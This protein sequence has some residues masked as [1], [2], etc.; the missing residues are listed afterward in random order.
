MDNEFT[1]VSEGKIKESIKEQLSQMPIAYQLAI[2]YF[3]WLKKCQEIGEKFNLLE[4]EIHDLKTKVALVLLGLSNMDALHEFLDNEIGGTGWEIIEDSIIENILD[5]MSELI[6]MIEKYDI[7]SPTLFYFEDIYTLDLPALLKNSIL[8]GTRDIPNNN[9]TMKYYDCKLDTTFLNAL[10]TLRIGFAWEEKEMKICPQ[11]FD[12]TLLP[13]NKK[14]NDNQIAFMVDSI[15]KSCEG[16]PDQ[17]YGL[18]DLMRFKGGTCSFMLF[19]HPNGHDIGISQNDSV[20]VSVNINI[21]YEDF[22]KFR[23]RHY[24]Y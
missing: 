17:A 21:T 15:F 8:S 19:D 3:G 20:G 22:L 23:G 5:P 18:S 16:S 10:D 24:S 12:L 1:L 13:K 2:N 6:E 9:L 7:N 11:T 4:K 14:L